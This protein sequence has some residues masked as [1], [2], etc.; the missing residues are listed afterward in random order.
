MKVPWIAR[1]KIALEA[2]NLINAFQTVAGYRVKPPIPVEDIIERSL[3][4]R[5]LYEDLEEVFRSDDV[6]GAMYVESGIIC[7]N[8]RMFEHS[9]E[10]RF[11]WVGVSFSN[12]T[13]GVLES[14]I[15][16]EVLIGRLHE[17][18]PCLC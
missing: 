4:L 3:G 18:A 16:L 14:G 1:E 6:L 12:P 9:S 15:V 8:E 13:R 7:I 2:M 5:L 17:I 11:V 10:G